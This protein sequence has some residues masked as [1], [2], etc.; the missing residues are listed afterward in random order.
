MKE[1]VTSPSSL[2]RMAQNA[3]FL[4]DGFPELP[5]KALLLLGD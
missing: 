4:G 3:D 5:R 1:A 2:K